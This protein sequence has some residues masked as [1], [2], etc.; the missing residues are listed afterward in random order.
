M[1]DKLIRQLICDKEIIPDM[2]AKIDL[3]EEEETK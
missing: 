2:I 1:K 3:Y